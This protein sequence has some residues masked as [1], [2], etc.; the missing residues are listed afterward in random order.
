MVFVKVE[1]LASMRVFYLAW[2]LDFLKKQQDK[3]FK[4]HFR[5]VEGPKKT[6]PLE[7]QHSP[8]LILNCSY[9]ERSVVQDSVQQLNVGK[10]RFTILEQQAL[11]F[12]L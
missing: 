5:K 10:T 7:K 6:H 3:N 4:K 8:N 2:L 11:H 9:V 1:L 12:F